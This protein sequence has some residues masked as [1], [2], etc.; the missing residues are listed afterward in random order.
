M[1]DD[2]LVENVNVEKRN[3]L[4]KNLVKAGLVGAGLIGVSSI[5]NASSVLWRTE[6]G[7]M[8][9][10]KNGQRIKHTT[11]FGR[12]WTTG[13]S[14]YIKLKSVFLSDERFVRVYANNTLLIFETDWEFNN[15]DGK[16]IGSVADLT[17]GVKILYPTN[18]VT[19]KV[20]FDEYVIPFNP[21]IALCRNDGK[22]IT[23][24]L[25]KNTISG[26]G[27]KTG[28]LTNI[29]EDDLTNFEY[30]FNYSNPGS[31]ILKGY[32]ATHF[33][34]SNFR[35]DEELP[36]GWRVEVYKLGRHW[37]GI[38][39]SE[40]GSYLSTMNSSLC[41]RFTFSNN[42]ESVGSFVEK[43]RGGI[44]CIRLRKVETNEV[45][46]FSI[47]KMR[48]RRWRYVNRSFVP[49]GSAIFRVSLI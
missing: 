4:K 11:S 25:P 1:L 6:T 16:K 33:F 7:E 12:T 44:F 15:T 47:Q 8:M 43:N 34:C 30:T 46:L 26:D 21:S 14:P 36:D 18:G 38:R 31:F 48:G 32:F 22:M 3:A 49:I 45:S 35:R 24:S 9:D 10:L 13:D 5:V 37:T 2:N 41:P 42:L 19:Y 20:E 29:I 27:G 23:K 40:G 39:A 17:D 28:V